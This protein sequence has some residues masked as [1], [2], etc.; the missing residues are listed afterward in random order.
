VKPLLAAALMLAAAAPAAAHTWTVGADGADFPLITPA[1]T[2]ARDGDTIIVGPGVY[3]ENLVLHRRVAIVGRGSPVLYGLGSG[4]VIRILAPGCEIRGLVI[5]GSGAG[6]TNEMDAAVQVASSGNVIAGNTMRRVFYGVVV[7]APDN[8]IADN[9]IVGFQDLPFGRR[10]DG[11]YVYRAASVRVRDNHVVGQRD[12]IYFQYA[13]DG[14]AEGNVVEGSRYGLHVMFANDIVVRGNSFGGSSVGAN[15]MDSRRIRIEGNRFQ[16]NRGASAVGLT[17]KGCDDSIVA[18]N[19]VIDNARGLQ[20]DGSSR[21]RI[22]DNDLVYNDTAVLVF[23][24]AEQNEFSGNVFDGNWNDVVVSGRGAGTA[25]NR[26]GRGN[27]WSGYRGFDFDGDGVG[28]APHPLVTPYAAIEG[29][30]PIARLFL[31]TPA[32]A[33]LDL[34]ARVGLTPGTGERDLHP[35]VGAPA[36]H[37]Q[38]EHQ[39]ATGAGMLAMLIVAMAG[40]AREGSSW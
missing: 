18:R 14:I 34:A 4:S 10:G 22:A 31:G 40:L 9:H 32:A 3:R 6:E 26:D 24:S 35:I 8:E 13:P 16:R 27:Y 11:I 39:G 21:N 20:V 12:G 37:R 30:N 29:A 38:A 1:L 33:G 15:I 2:A 7:A 36:G 5:E 25:W 28:E 17:L 23:A 19:S